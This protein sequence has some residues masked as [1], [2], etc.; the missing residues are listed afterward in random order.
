M[1]EQ[2]YWMEHLFSVMCSKCSEFDEIHCSSISKGKEYYRK[3][4]WTVGDKQVLCP[5]CNGKG[6]GLKLI[7]EENE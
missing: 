1:K 6:D 7:K 5:N 4:G 2:N 3:H